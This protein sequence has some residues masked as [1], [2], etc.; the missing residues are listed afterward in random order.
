MFDEA[1]ALVAGRFSRVEP[2]RTAREFVLGLLSGVERKNCWWLAEQAGHATP[3]AMQR[4]LSVAVW[5]A[6]AVRDDVRGYVWAQLGHPDGALIADETGFLKKGR[7][8]VGVQRQYTGTA[9]RIENSQVGVFLSY[10]CPRG[11]A[12][13]DRRVYLPKSWTDDPA[14]CA[15]AGIPDDVAFATKPTLALAMICAAL[16]AGVSARWVTCDEVYG[17]D[18]AFRAG[19]QARRLGYV[20]AVACDHRV[21]IDGG[22]VRL[23][24]DRVADSLPEASWQRR[25]AGAGS[26]GP[27]LYDWAWVDIATPDAPGHSLLIRRASDGEPAYYRCWSPAPVTL[28]TLVRVAGLRWCVEEGFQA[29]KGQVGLDHYQIRSWTAWHRFTILA[30]LAL[31]FLAV[32]AA[33]APPRPPNP[34]HWAHDDRPI[35]LTCNEIR[36]L[37]AN[38]I[39]TP[40]RA[41]AHIQACS[42]WRRRHQGRARHAHYRR[43]ITIEFGP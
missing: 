7:H 31:A 22:R 24:A 38:L 32:A 11:R 42:W 13:I 25:S 33:T 37:I 27:R 23:R 30:M 36:H 4:L 15:A 2:R 29:G 16:D 17:G 43:R 5:D 12:L 35:A 19:L 10:A 8:S 6:D 40:A 3:D 1:M 18:P 9:G 26:K 28:A 21:P 20:L 14:R 41:P 39:I 34:N